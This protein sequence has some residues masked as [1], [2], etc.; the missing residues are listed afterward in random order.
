LPGLARRDDLG[1]TQRA[2]SEWRWRVRRLAV[3]SMMAVGLALCVPGWAKPAGASSGRTIL[4]PTSVKAVPVDGGVL[5][6]W[7]PLP[8]GGPTV[9]YYIATTYSRQHTCQVPGTGPYHCVLT[10]LNGNR[11]FLINV[12]AVTTSGVSPPGRAT[13]TVIPS[14]AKPAATAAASTAAAHAPVTAATS[15]PPA[16]ST[17]GATLTDLPF[18][19]IDVLTILLVGLG[20][21]VSGLL[22]MTRR[23]QHRRAR[24]RV[25]GS[26]TGRPVGGR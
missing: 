16:T 15:A 4:P 21:C 14:P 10:G 13:Q 6:S 23:P 2:P 24:Q 8:A 12:Q 19:G 3:V 20:L 22:L 26:M 18:T 25:S 1:A 11:H 5:V 9:L 7:Q 17:T